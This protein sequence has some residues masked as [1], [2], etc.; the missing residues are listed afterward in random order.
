MTALAISMRCGG[1]AENAQVLD[2]ALSAACVE[3]LEALDRSGATRVALERKVVVSKSRRRERA[4][5]DP[6][7]HVGRM[8]T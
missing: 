4:V 8:R 1:D 2:F 3:E 5:R 6:G 7:A